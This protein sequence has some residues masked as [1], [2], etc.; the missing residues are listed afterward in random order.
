MKKKLAFLGILG[1]GT[2]WCVHRDKKYPLAKGYGLFNKVVINAGLINT[3]TAKMANKAIDLRGIPAVEDGLVRDGLDI[4]TRDDQKIHLTIYR[5][6]DEKG[7]RPCLVY[8]HGG[9]FFLKDDAYIHKIVMEYAK[10]ARCTV[11][12]VHYR[13]ADEY[14]F[15]TPFYDCAD[16]INYVYEHVDELM[17]DKD[18]I[19]VGG[20]SAGGALAASITHFCKE[21]GIGIC[22]QMLVYPVIDMRMQTRSAKAYKDA[23]LWN[24][25][26]SKKM[27]EIYLRD[28]IK[29]KQEYASPILA[30]DFSGLPNAYIEVCEFDSL[31]DEGV[32]YADALMTAGNIV[33][34]VE[35]KGGIHGFDVLSDT[36]LTKRAMKKRCDALYRAFYK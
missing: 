26:M 25:T 14:P 29:D 33:E 7:P 2:A 18:R 19:A 23:P 20:D 24:S 4:K 9:G 16:A 1:L 21:K 12:F 28:G 15:P 13:T 17:I 11:I 31:H 32:E 34:L 35:S 27:W 22:F 6:Q 8:F 30:E 3:H 10:K 36:E 5:A